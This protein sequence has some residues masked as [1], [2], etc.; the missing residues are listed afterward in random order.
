MSRTLRTITV[1]E[2]RDLLDGEDENALVIFTTDYGDYHHT[3]QALPIKGEIEE[4]TVSESAYSNSGF[5]LH[6]DEDDDDRSEDGEC[7]DCGAI[8]DEPHTKDCRYNQKYLVIR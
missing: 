7:A 8:D 5:Q 1:R 2:L 6:T 4:G 3:P